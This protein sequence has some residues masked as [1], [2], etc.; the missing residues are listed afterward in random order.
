MGSATS[1]GTALGANPCV[2]LLIMVNKVVY[3]ENNT[4][5]CTR[6]RSRGTLQGSK[7]ARGQTSCSSQGWQPSA[8]SLLNAKP[9]VPGTPPIH[10]LYCICRMHMQ[11]AI[12]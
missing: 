4:Q 2:L 12:N 1:G 8:A 6:Q 9:R 3:M 11:I 7:N 10:H 5:E